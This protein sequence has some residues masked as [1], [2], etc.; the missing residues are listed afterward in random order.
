MR[1]H[2]RRRPIRDDL[3]IGRLEEEEKRISADEFF[4]KCYG[5][6]P[7]WAVLLSGLRNREG[8]T[9]KEFGEMIGVA[10]YHVSRMERGLRP[11]GKKIAE[12]ISKV[13]KVDYRLFL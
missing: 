8:L 2:T 4:N 1:G 3:G 11:I 9:Q 7:K 13:F 12:R 5:N 6:F 10:Q